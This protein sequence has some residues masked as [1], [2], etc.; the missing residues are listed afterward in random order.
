V[1]AV[2]LCAMAFF[3]AWLAIMYIIMKDEQIEL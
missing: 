2:A 1:I 3:S